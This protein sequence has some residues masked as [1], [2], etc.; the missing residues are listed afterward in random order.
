MWN[1]K[2]LD[3]SAIESKVNELKAK[4][5]EYEKNNSEEGVKAAV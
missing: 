5:N 2:V 1:E 4:V 3:I